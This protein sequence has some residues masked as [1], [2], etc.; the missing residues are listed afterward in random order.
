MDAKKLLINTAVIPKD[1]TIIVGFS[2]GPDSLCLL[3]QLKLLKDEYNLKLIAAHL[4]HGW[5][6]HSA[7]DVQHCKHLCREWDIPFIAGHARDFEENVKKTGS[8]EDV[9]RRMRRSFFKQVAHEHNAQAIALGHHHNDQIENFFIRMVRGTTL[10]G[11]AGMQ[12]QQGL[13]IRPL[14]N[15]TKED[16]LQYLADNH[17]HYL[18]DPSNSNEEF[19]R[20]R[21]RAHLVPA[22]ARCDTRAMDNVMRTFEHIKAAETFLQ[23]LTQQMFTQLLVKETPPTVDLKKFS[24][25]DR[26]LQYRILQ[27]W[28]TSYAPSFTLTEA[29]L[30]EVMRFLESPRGGTHQ[31]GT[32][33][34]M[35][36][37]QHQ[38]F[39]ET[40]C[41]LTS[42]AA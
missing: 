1:S 8:K 38:A 12:E 37:K 3:H 25:L 35:I 6:E 31:L 2:G 40:A 34:H 26:F 19:L 7:D 24:S 18:I 41:S 42:S 39:I 28:I 29:F 23:N 20:N 16:I 15:A 5:R 4:D 22:L 27:Y 36:K 33:W 30:D 11:L 13:Y 10:T 32:G 14:L 17:L 9:G 21:I